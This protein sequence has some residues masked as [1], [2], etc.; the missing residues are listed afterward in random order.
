MEIIWSLWLTA[1][2]TD[3]DCRYQDVQWFDKQEQCLEMLPIYKAIP[4]DGEWDSV[5]YV[6][7]P[8]NSES[9]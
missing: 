3:T 6:C 9:T 8:L 4:Q 2:F 7:K 1:C 5:T